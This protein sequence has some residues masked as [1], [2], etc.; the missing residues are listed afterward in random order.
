MR[1]CSELKRTVFWLIS[2]CQCLK[3]ELMNA[4]VNQV[5]QEKYRAKCQMMLNRY[6][7][8]VN[9]H[10]KTLPLQKELECLSSNVEELKAHSMS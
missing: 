7:L 5:V 3:L 10:E 9:E 1:L 8:H 4:G 2:D 6:G